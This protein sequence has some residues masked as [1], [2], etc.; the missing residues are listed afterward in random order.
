MYSLFNKHA[1]D[2]I[3]KPPS[4]TQL[5]ATPQQTNRILKTEPQEPTSAELGCQQQSHNHAHQQP[6]NGEDKGGANSGTGHPSE[7][8]QFEQRIV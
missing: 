2:L 1:C 8:I 5:P 3:L 7:L 4:A 6:C